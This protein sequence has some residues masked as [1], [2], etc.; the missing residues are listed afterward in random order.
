MRPRLCLAALQRPAMRRM[1]GIRS[2]L[3]AHSI[4]PSP[5]EARELALCVI[6]A[7]NTWAMFVRYFYVS[8]MLGARTI[9]GA[10]VTQTVGGVNSE[11]DAIAFAKSVV[12]GL[13]EDGPLSEPQWHTSTTLL[14]I[15][16]SAGLSNEQQIR[17]AYSVVGRALNDL[18]K[19]R[20]FFAHR[21]QGTALVL[22]GLQKRYGLSKD[23][24]PGLIPAQ[25]HPTEQHTIAHAWVEELI[26]R[27]RLLPE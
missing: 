8:C 23:T 24:K 15:A 16:S 20:N 22:V 5:S 19:A 14:P 10:R 25:R 26:H 2:R 18:P 6:E 1:A 17:V 27:V 13:T 12:K 9:S 3:A 11:A 7:Q 21:S 4:P